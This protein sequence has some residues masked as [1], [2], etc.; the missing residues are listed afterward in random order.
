MIGR[1][2]TWRRCR[3]RASAR[4]GSGPSG[5]S[6]AAATAAPSAGCRRTGCRREPAAGSADAERLERLAAR[7]RAPCRGRGCRRASHPGR[8][9]PRLMLSPARHI[10]EQAERFA[11][12]GQVGDAGLERILGRADRR[13]AC[14]PAAR[15]PRPLD[16]RRRPDAQVRCAR[17]RRARQC[18][19]PRRA[20]SCRL[21]GC[22]RRPPSVMARTSITHRSVAVPRH[23]GPWCRRWTGH[24][25]PSSSPACRD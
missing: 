16:R 9:T 12:L 3:R 20:C 2:R 24:A 10:E 5:R 14:R 21:H 1:S 15:R 6:P 8:C 19:A 22:T 11:V 4:P 25:R 18:P 17:R 7:G 23:H 13:P